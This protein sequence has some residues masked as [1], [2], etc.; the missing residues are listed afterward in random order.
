M[1]Q[2]REGDA[3]GPVIAGADVRRTD[4]R[5]GDRIWDPD[6]DRA[7]A[8][9]VK[10]ARVFD[11]RLQ[12]ERTALAWQRTLLSLAVASL[13]V[14]RGLEPVIGPASWAVASVG[15][16]VTVTMFVVTRR[17]YLQVHQHLTTIDA[18]SLP[19]GAHLITSAAAV[20]V[21]AGLSAL[22]FVLHKRS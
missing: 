13:A 19:H 15:L 1:D 9:A 2:C 16:G 4:R 21:V 22:A 5:C 6:R 14:G 8:L 20:N 11:E 7:P 10:S 17:T 12:L 3:V 18:H